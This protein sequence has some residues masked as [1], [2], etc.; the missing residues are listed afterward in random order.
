M[1]SESDKLIIITNIYQLYF[2]AIIIIRCKVW[3]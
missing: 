1:E 3:L 2:I